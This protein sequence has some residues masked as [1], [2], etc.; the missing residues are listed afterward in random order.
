MDKIERWIKLYQQI[1]C[2]HVLFQFKGSFLSRVK[3]PLGLPRYL[4]IHDHVRETRAQ[5]PKVFESRVSLVSSMPGKWFVHSQNWNLSS[6]W[7]HLKLVFN[8]AAVCFTNQRTST[9]STAL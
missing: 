9:V 5:G 8:V 6:S 4:G 3:P 1:S 7:E 2:I